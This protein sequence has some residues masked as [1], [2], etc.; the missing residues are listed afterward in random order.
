MQSA[1]GFN[2]AKKISFAVAVV[3]SKAVTSVSNGKFKSSSEASNNCQ[4]KREFG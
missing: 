3:Q 1:M 2:I 4:K